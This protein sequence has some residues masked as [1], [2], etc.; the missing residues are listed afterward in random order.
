[1][2]HVIKIHI[3]VERGIECEVPEL[4]IVGYNVSE[5]LQRL[6]I[7][8]AL[9]TFKEGYGHGHRVFIGWIEQSMYEVSVQIQ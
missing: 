3:T 8:I 1:M 6:R 5:C 2:N 9:D 4:S 7:R